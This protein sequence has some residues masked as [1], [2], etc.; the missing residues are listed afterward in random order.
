MAD[1]PKKRPD[2]ARRTPRKPT[3]LGGGPRAN[4]EEEDDGPMG[5]W[6]GHVPRDV[7]SDD[8]I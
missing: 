7:I 6:T 2:D 5:T 4:E 8:K 3:D 1:T